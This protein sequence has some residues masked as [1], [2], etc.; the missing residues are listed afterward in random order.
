MSN[1]YFFNTN[2]IPQCI[3]RIR[4]ERDEPRWYT[5][6][7][8]VKRSDLSPELTKYFQDRLPFKI[9]DAGFLS[10]DPISIYDPHIDPNR[11]FAINILLTDPHPLANTYALEH[12]LDYTGVRPVVV[13]YTKDAITLLNTKKIHWIVNHSSSER[14][15]L[16]IGCN[17]ISY[18]EFLPKIMSL[19]HTL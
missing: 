15:V 12:N 9:T 7:F 2:Y 16:S 11:T 4:I 13:G 3:D 14:I 10:R 5:S 8:G 6:P 18:L 17:S 1:A 19:V